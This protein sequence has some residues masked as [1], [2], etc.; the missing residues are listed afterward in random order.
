MPKI[1]VPNAPKNPRREDYDPGPLPVEP[2]RVFAPVAV[3]DIQTAKA[4]LENG[5]IRLG[6]MAAQG[7]KFTMFEERSITAAVRD[8]AETLDL[9]RK[10]LTAYREAP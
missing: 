9:T 1:Q 2:L 8:L 4:Y 3:G 10:A 6:S 7:E 5:L